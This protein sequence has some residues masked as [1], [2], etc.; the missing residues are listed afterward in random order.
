M[1]S[2]LI[3]IDAQRHAQLKTYANLLGI[4]MAAVVEGY[5]E[6]D[7]IPKVNEFMTDDDAPEYEAEL[8]KANALL[9]S[10]WLLSIHKWDDDVL[11]VGLDIGTDITPIHISPDQ[12]RNFASDLAELG[13]NGGAQSPVIECT[14]FGDKISAKRKGSGI[15]LTRTHQP[16]AQD[17]STS[18]AA[19]LATDVA[20]A[21]EMAANAAERKPK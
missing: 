19:R 8:N 1:P 13:N 15:I 7:L 2:A 18:I 3:R 14:K 6:N 10:R 9:P 11:T 21:F 12:L 4:S 17:V 16:E 5:I 20:T